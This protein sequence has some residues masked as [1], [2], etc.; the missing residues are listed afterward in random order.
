MGL[1]MYAFS[2]ERADKTTA[3]K[4]QA[5]YQPDDEGALIFKWRKHGALH[6]WMRDLY[7]ESGGE[8]DTF[9]L[10]NLAISKTVLY[11]LEDDLRSSQV[12]GSMGNHYFGELTEE[13][14]A[15]DLEFTRIAREHIDRGNVVYYSSWW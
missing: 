1:D 5:D 6:Q 4:T 2:V 8:D 7:Y 12:E 11:E 10:V 3:Y 9:N 15:N 14:I 13:E